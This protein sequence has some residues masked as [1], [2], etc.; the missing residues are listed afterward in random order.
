[1]RTIEE[2][3]IVNPTG[4]TLFNLSMED[5]VDPTLV[6][7]YFA[8]IQLFLQHLGNKKLKTIILKDFKIVI[9]QGFKKILFISR[10]KKGVK[11]E[12]IIKN[13][14]FVEKSFKKEYYNY[15][16]NWDGNIEIFS[17]FGDKIMEIFDDTPEKRTKDALW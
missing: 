1:M 13:L 2:L 11:D 12:H 3:W 9:L 8:A 10:S 7:G 15:I 17:N 6:G 14:K 16:D 4:I 5:I